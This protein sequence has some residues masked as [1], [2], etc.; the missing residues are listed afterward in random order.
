MVETSKMIH[1]TFSKENYENACD[2]SESQ[3]VSEFGGIVYRFC[4]SLVY[5]KEDADD[6]FQD[7]YVR[8]F[9]EIEK[10]RA[11]GN[12]KSFLL[13]VATSLWRSNRR[14]YARRNRL[15]PI[16]DFDEANIIEA[17]SLED[18]AIANEEVLMVRE[19]VNDLPNKLKVT[20]VMYYTVE[21][22]IADIARTLKLPIGT[23]KSQLS[24]ARAIIRKG[25]ENKYGNE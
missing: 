13:S 23:V 14:K 12:P 10:I 3:L 25:L 20:V 22:S 21:M 7:T 18:R 24:R 2:I 11:S 9:S 15:A 4:I 17:E 6:L 19:L 1:S 8:A 5:R 16:V